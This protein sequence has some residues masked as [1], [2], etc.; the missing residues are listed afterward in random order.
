MVGLSYWAGNSNAYSTWKTVWGTPEVGKYDSNDPIVITKH[1]QW[2]SDAGVDFIFVDWSN[3]LPYYPG[4]KLYPYMGFIENS[5]Y[6]IADTFATLQKHPQIAIMIGFPGQPTAVTDGRLQRKADQVYNDFLANPKRAAVYQ[7]YE[8][9]PLLLVYAGT[10]TP[11]QT[12]L[13][14]WN[15]SR[16]TVRF[17]TGFITQ[18]ANLIGVGRVSRYGYLSWEDRGA[19]T[20]TLENGVPEAMS[21]VA[22][23]RADIGAHVE[24]RARLGGTTFVMEWARARAIGVNLV[25]VTSWNEWQTSEQIDAE[26]GKDLE[27]SLEFG[28]FYLNLLK[29]QIAQFKAG[30]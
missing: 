3:D 17:I 14:P 5:T 6:A 4:S 29:Q 16:F 10:P 11:Y 2:L 26:Q 13:P 27:P 21:V 28:E 12:G 1:A 30:Q 22:A 8:G 7:Y 18:Q 9:K 20:Y 15:D 19:Q 24:G 23:W 25:L